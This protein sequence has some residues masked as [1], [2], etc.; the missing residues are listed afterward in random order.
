MTLKQVQSLLD[1]A[2]V[3]RLQHLIL[4][5]TDFKSTEVDTILNKLQQATQ[6]QSVT[7]LGAVTTNEQ[8]DRMK[9]RKVTLEGNNVA[10]LDPVNADVHDPAV[11]SENH[12][13]Y[14]QEEYVFP[15]NCY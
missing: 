2:N 15:G 5:C 4:P 14:Y 9:A 11:P 12:A 6:L 10:P 1:A 8:T 3:S 13:P 7:L